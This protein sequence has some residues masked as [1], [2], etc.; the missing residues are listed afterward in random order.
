MALICFWVTFFFFNFFS[1]A[2]HVMLKKIIYIPKIH[3]TYSFQ[4]YHICR[5]MKLTKFFRLLQDTEEKCALRYDYLSAL[6]IQ[7]KTTC[8]DFHSWLDGS[9]ITSNRQLTK[10]LRIKRSL[11]WMAK[12]ILNY[13]CQFEITSFE[14]LTYA[15]CFDVIK[16]LKNYYA[17]L[18]MIKIKRAFMDIQICTGK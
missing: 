11:R 12:I 18:E 4:I 9:R 2:L 14:F 1:D 3:L 5:F 15:Y 10:S 16:L 17:C 6:I 8:I 7:W 13:S